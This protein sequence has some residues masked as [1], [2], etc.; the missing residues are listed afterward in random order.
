MNKLHVVTVVTESKYY[1]PYLVKTCKR[2]GKELE[3]LGYGEKWEGFNW[4]Y[5]KM[6]EYLRRLPKDDIVCFVDGYD[7]VCC[8][9]L[10]EMIP[11]F[12]KIKE[13][14]GC[15]MIVGIDNGNPIIMFFG[16]FLFGEY[17]NQQL[18]AG[19]YIGFVSDVL[20]IIEKVYKLNPNNDADDQV[21]MTD[22]CQQNDKE[23]YIDSKNQL[24]LALCHPLYEIDK[25]VEINQETH[26]LTYNSNQPF[27]IHANGSGYLNG[28]ISKLGYDI[29]D[30]EIKNELFA[31]LLEKKIWHYIKE[32]F[33]KFYF[34]LFFIL[35]IIIFIILF[36]YNFT[37]FTDTKKKLYK[38]NKFT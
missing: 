31:N 38:K 12:I 15:K 22:Y 16:K 20:E 27:F 36:I 34:I 1:F 24:F 23:I 6:M 30:D 33:L 37:Y 3:V 21:L 17:N 10:N 18:N 14:T 13:T 9:D 35:F 2:N 5:I 28:V 25:H 19:T 7:V 11:E 32:V 8:R 4:R 26:I 29:K